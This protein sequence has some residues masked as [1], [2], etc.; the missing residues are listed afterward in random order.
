MIDLSSILDGIGQ[1]IRLLSAPPT[2]TWYATMIQSMWGRK[3]LGIFITLALQ[4]PQ[5]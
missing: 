2:M 3:M 5:G 4:G 1:N